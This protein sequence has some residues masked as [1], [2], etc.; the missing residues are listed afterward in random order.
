[1]FISSPMSSPPSPTLLV[2]V[3]DRLPPSSSNATL[4][5]LKVFLDSH[6][7]LR[8]SNRCALIGARSGRAAFVGRAAPKAAG[9]EQAANAPPLRPG[10][11]DVAGRGARGAR[12]RSRPG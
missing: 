5:A 11:V 2:L 1:M 4:N 10:G 7:I 12:A 8:P 6:L 9:P 3:V